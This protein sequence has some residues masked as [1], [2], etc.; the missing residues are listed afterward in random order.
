MG[1][2]S[3]QFKKFFSTD[4]EFLEAVH[5][6]TNQYPKNES[7]Y[8]LALVHK[9]ASLKLN[10]G[11]LVN[12]ERLE[13]LGDAVMDAVVAEYL[14][15]NYPDKPEGFLTQ[16]RAKIVNGDSLAHLALALGIDKFIVSHVAN[17]NTNKN[18]LGDAF[19]AMVGALYLDHGYK[20]VQRF[21]YKH[22]I[23]KY[24]NLHEVVNTENNYKSRLLEWAQHNKRKVVFEVEEERDNAILTFFAS[25]LV[26]GNRIAL[27]S[28]SS[29]KEAEQEASQKALSQLLQQ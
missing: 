7:L 22:L 8:K 2:I 3:F 12:N 1:F 25:V 18:I 24:I 10:D 19:E 17:Y 14:Y 29:K 9:S 26:D 27:G 11:Q 16:T 28:G 20:A 6:I 13:Y 4:K 23:R 15:H 5:R 21:V